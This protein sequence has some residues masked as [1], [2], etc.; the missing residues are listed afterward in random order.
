M[1]EREGERDEDNEKKKRVGGRERNRKAGGV[2]GRGGGKKK[3]ERGRMG[4]NETERGSAQRDTTGGV[5]CLHP[6]PLSVM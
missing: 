4:K 1:G 2:G 3:K 5:V 6:R